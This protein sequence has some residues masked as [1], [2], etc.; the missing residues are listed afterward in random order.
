MAPSIFVSFRQYL[1]SE[2]LS[3]NSLLVSLQYLNL[4]CFSKFAVVFIS[5]KGAMEVVR[6]SLSS[7]KAFSNRRNLKFFHLPETRDLRKTTLSP[8]RQFW[9]NHTRLSGLCWVISTK[10]ASAKFGFWLKMRSVCLCFSWNKSSFSRFHV[11][12][13]AFFPLQKRNAWWTA[14]SKDAHKPAAEIARS[15][16]TILYASTRALDRTC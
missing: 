2:L 10:G 6:T 11:F 13:I 8:T 1:L 12:Q 7:R 16:K 15:M 3:I 14:L 9:W 4:P 5:P